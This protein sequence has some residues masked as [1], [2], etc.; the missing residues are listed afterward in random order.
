MEGTINQDNASKV[1]AKL[2][3]EA[4]NGPVTF[5]ADTIL[6]NNG[7]IILPDAY[8]NA[9]G[10]VVSYF[11][12]VRNL[13]HM[14]FGR[15]ERRLDE[16]RGQH[17]VRALEEATEKKMPDWVLGEL[18]HGSDELD[19][20]RSGLDD[21]MRVAYQEIRE[22]KLSNDKVKDYRTAAYVIAVEK[23]KRSYSDLG[24]Y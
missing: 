18:A 12:W 16:L 14:R 15:M 2:I 4:A 23:I 7:T 1:Q 5:E 10:V 8:V 20:V 9:G 19:L 6:C 22:I 11:E 24:I 21:T 13:S 17:I 3:C